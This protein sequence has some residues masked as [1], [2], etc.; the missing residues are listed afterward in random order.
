MLR[1]LFTA[2]NEVRDV[3]LVLIGA[4]LIWKRC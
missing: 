2:E 3:V 4:L 1:K